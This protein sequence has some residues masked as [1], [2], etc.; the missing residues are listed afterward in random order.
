VFINATVIQINYS[1]SVITAARRSKIVPLQAQVRRSSNPRRAHQ[2]RAMAMQGESK[3]AACGS[4][5]TNETSSSVVRC[6]RCGPSGAA[7]PS[8]SAALAAR[9]KGKQLPPRP[10][11]GSGLGGKRCS[12][13]HDEE[14]LSSSSAASKRHHRLSVPQFRVA[15]ARVS[16]ER[17]EGEDVE[18][19]EDLDDGKDHFDSLPIL[20]FPVRH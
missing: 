19:E 3:P 6:K 1:V 13:E 11:S 7:E 9:G 5:L 15:S 18:S 8:S 10:T 17:E 2:N 20:L 4:P 14:L 12:P 16:D